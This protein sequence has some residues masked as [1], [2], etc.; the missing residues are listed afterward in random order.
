VGKPVD[1]H[2]CKDLGPDGID[3]LTF[4][5]SMAD[6]HEL[7]MQG[8]GVHRHDIIKLVVKATLQSGEELVGEDI[9]DIVE[10]R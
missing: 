10:T 7:L 8:D 3:D 6:V 4:K 9:A 5:L 2:A 1:A